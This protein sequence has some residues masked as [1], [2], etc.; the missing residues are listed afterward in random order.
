MTLILTL[1]AANKI[2]QVSDRLLTLNGKVHEEN[3]NKAICV[4]C[5]NAHFS[6]GYTGVAE[7]DGQRT[8]YWIV[9]QI[10]SIFSLG[11]QDIG[12]VGQLLGEKLTDVFSELKYEGLPIGLQDKGLKLVLAGFGG[13]VDG[14]H[15]DPFLAHIT[16]MMPNA[17]DT[18]DVGSR[19]TSEIWIGRDALQDGSRDKFG[20]FISGTR[21][22]FTVGDNYSSGLNRCAKQVRR[23][24]RRID[25]GREPS[26]R[27]TADRLAWLIRQ[28]SRHPRYRKFI[29]RD[30]LSTVIHPGSGPFLT[31]YHP[32]KAATIEYGPHLVTP[33][34][35]TWDVEFNLDPHI[36][37]LA[38]PS[39]AILTTSH[40]RANDSVQG[41]D[42]DPDPLRDSLAHYF[43]AYY[44]EARSQLAGRSFGIET[45]P[46]HLM[47]WR[48]LVRMWETRDGHFVVQHVSNAS[49][50]PHQGNE[51][52]RSDFGEDYLHLYPRK[53]QTLREM[54]GVEVDKGA[55]VHSVEIRGK[56]IGDAGYDEVQRGDY[57][58][59]VDAISRDKVAELTEEAA[60]EA[61]RADMQPYLDLE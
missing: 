42:V 31:H 56:R 18:F 35:S 29:G 16:N 24:L 20:L 44:Q 52:G 57:L 47:P 1:V 4:S 48:K 55:F 53:D 10:Q 51:S 26:S 12:K 39:E 32:E 17:L 6:I 5:S 28:A 11:Y 19:F 23:Q 3:A 61:A 13:P 41:D 2:V 46:S 37:D 45:V 54:T 25:L 36:P 59:R 33:M 40:R 60:R 27:T 14:M 49:D 50:S 9:D 43:A 30:C 22:P 8:D 7:I 38:D 34:L 15:T 58:E 21:A